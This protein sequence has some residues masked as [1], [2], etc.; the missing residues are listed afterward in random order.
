MAKGKNVPIKYTNRDF[1]SIKE[2]LINYTKRYHPNTYNDFSDSS[3]G[4]IIFP[5]DLDIFFPF[6][7]ITN[8]WVR[9]A[10]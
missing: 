8:P 9:T 4:E 10:L 1:N 7:S 5:S 2:E 3:F 6:S